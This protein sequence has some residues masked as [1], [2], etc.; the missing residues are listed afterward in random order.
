[1]CA[2]LTEFS[3]HALLHL[4][5]NVVQDV[6]NVSTFYYTGNQVL[7]ELCL[8]GRANFKITLL[9]C[10]LL[11]RIKSSMRLTLK[12]DNS[13]SINESVVRFTK[14]LQFMMEHFFQFKRILYG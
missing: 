10:L 3:D 12:G 14:E 7:V 1:M 4:Q 6:N 9:R 2:I 13:N 11:T 8:N 5:P